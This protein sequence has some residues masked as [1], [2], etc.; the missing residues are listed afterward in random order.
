MS[1]AQ[2]VCRLSL[3]ALLVVLGS[4]QDGDRELPDC[5]NLSFDV[6]ECAPLYQPTFDNLFEQTLSDG[7]APQ[8][9]SCHTHPDASG[10]RPNGLVFSDADTAHAALMGQ[11]EGRPFVDEDDASCS[12]LVVRVAVDDEDFRMPPGESPVDD[13]VVCAIA[14]WIEAGAER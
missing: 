5:V 8:G 2:R 9:D 1:Q 6:D 11:S 3:P 13:K 10:A 4:C 12:L 7:C 14:Q